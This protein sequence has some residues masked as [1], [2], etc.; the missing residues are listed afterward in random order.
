MFKSSL[1]HIRREHSDVALI[2]LIAMTITVITM[3]S[4]RHRWQVRRAGGGESGAILE[5]PR[6]IFLRGEGRQRE[7]HGMGHEASTIAGTAETVEEGAKGAGDAQGRV[8]QGRRDGW[9][10]MAGKIPANA[11][12]RATGRVGAQAPRASSSRYRADERHRHRCQ[13]TSNSTSLLNNTGVIV[14][15]QSRDSR[16]RAWQ[17][18]FEFPHNRTLSLSRRCASILGIAWCN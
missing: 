14:I 3:I 11:R 4:G 8:G 2:L 6:R 10:K 18:E 13:P 1:L 15:A 16:S 7:R 17:R 9:V 5:N 12:A